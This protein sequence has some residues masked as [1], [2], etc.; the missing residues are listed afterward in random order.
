MSDARGPET[1]G[2]STLLDF[3]DNRLLALLFGEHDRHLARIEER[4]GVAV[5]SR[6]NRLMIT[7]AADAQAQAK[8]FSPISIVASK[9]APNWRWAMSMVPSA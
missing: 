1:S 4:L 2:Q 8:K 9:V 7:G 3:D 6:G 5:A